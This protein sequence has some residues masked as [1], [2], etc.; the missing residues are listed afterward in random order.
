MEYSF[1]STF[2][3]FFLYI[4]HIG[5]VSA[6]REKSNT[7]FGSMFDLPGLGFGDEDGKT[8]GGGGG[9]S[10]GGGGGGSGRSGRRDGSIGEA[11]EAPMPGQPLYYGDRIRLF[12]KSNYVK[13]EDDKGGHVGVYESRRAFKKYHGFLLAGAL[14]FVCLLLLLLLFF[15]KSIF[16]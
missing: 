12:T 16:F 8:G 15:K 2:F 7:L 11:G 10:G 14:L 5:I 6:P 9:G 4:K 13:D 3:F 1:F